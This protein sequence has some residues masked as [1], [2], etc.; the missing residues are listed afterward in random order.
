M[1]FLIHHEAI[2]AWR[3]WSRAFCVRNHCV[4]LDQSVLRQRRNADN[5]TCRSISRE[6]RG[7]NFVNRC[8]IGNVLH[9]DIDLDHVGHGVIDALH[10]RLDVGQTLTGLLLDTA[11]NQIACLGV[12]RQLCRKMV[13]MRERHGL[14]RQRA[15]RCFIRIVCLDDKAMAIFNGFAKPLLRFAPARATA[16]PRQKRRYVQAY[17]RQ[18]GQS[19]NPGRRSCKPGLRL[20]YPTGS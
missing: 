2:P 19:T 6:V 3:L 7:I 10:D 18:C 14:R 16:N 15:L 17:R 8:D 5:A 12:D 20:R 4:D 13:V 9:E 1:H 11:S